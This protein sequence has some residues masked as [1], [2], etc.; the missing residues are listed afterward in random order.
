MGENN[1]LSGL[2]LL[3]WLIPAAALLV[4]IFISINIATKNV[5]K[6]ALTDAYNNISNYADELGKDVCPVQG[7]PE[8]GG[9]LHR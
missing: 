3:Q 4:F 7:A 6:N 9:K 1:K 2:S 8:R 5:E